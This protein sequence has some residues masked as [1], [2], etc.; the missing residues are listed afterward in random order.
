VQ[1][2]SR[3]FPE[4]NVVAK[5]E[6]K[7]F[8]LRDIQSGATRTVTTDY[9][10]NV[11]GKTIATTLHFLSDEEL[12]GSEDI[13]T[14]LE[15]E[16]VGELFAGTD[17]YTITEDGIEKYTSQYEQESNTIDYSSL[18]TQNNHPSTGEYTIYNAEGGYFVYFD[19]QTPDRKPS[20]LFEVP[21]YIPKRTYEKAKQ[22]D[23][24]N[25]PEPVSERTKYITESI[26]NDGMATWVGNIL[27]L[28]ATKTGYTTQKELINYISTFVQSL[29]YALDPISTGYR[30][31]S[32]YPAETLVDGK[33]DCVDT[34]IL[35]A[36][37][38]LESSVECNAAFFSFEPEA[39]RAS[40]SGHLAIGI[41]PN[42][43]TYPNKPYLQ[44]GDQR[45][46]Y[47]EPT[48]FHDVGAVPSSIDFSKV[49]L[50]RI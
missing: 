3:T 8:S 15:L 36:A 40:E 49:E 35:L 29:P 31:Y 48:A 28:L 1:A 41:S 45:Y 37:G 17:P 14:G 16:S 6:S 43:V 2:I 50:T 26:E 44:V 23:R 46:Y 10:E 34:S 39:V 22:T 9:T 42:N 19:T 13:P 27:D 33:G 7:Q 38:L 20:I 24:P 25:R 32:R 21:F 30:D 18:S 4:G 12:T 11:I 47:I 5:G